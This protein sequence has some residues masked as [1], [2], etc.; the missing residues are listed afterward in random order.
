[1]VR[2]QGRLL[3]SKAVFA[4]VSK[5]PAVRPLVA[6]FDAGR[7]CGDDLEGEISTP[8]AFIKVLTRRASREKEGALPVI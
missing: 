5:T 1:M 3:F 8:A 2:G 4:Q 7:H 6:R